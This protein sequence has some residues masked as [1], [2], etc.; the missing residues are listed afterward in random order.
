MLEEVALRMLRAVFGGGAN[1]SA[2]NPLPVDT[3]PGSKTATEVLTEAIIALATTTVIGDCDSID[4]SGG[5]PTLTLT[6]E[7]TY[8]AGAILGIRI[9]VRTSFDDADW[10]SIDWDVWNPSFT[11]G[12][13]IRQTM[14][15]DSSPMYVRVLVENLDA[16][17]SV[18]DVAV[19][20]TVG[21]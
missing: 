2:A 12:A 5:P 1:I 11:A 13:T 3:S 4:L 19:I 6:V 17:Q 15:Y 7:A 9:H 20:A 10:D 18:T 14:H 21:A 16:A 8:N